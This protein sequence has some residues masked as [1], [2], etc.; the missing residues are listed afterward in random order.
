VAGGFVYILASRYRGTL[1]T[2]VTAN[3]RR[4]VWEHRQGLGSEHVSQYA[5]TRLVW[6]EPHAAIADAIA[7]EKTIKRWPRA[8]KFNVI[9]AQ[10][11]EWRDL[12]EEINA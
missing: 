4:R 8:W 5:V 1:Y 9:E 12:W 3:L 6:A 10:N 11:P 2:G 7:R